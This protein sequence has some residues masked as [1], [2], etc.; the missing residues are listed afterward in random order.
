MSK[1]LKVLKEFDYD[2]IKSYRNGNPYTIAF[3][4]MQNESFCVKGGANDVHKFIL[5][6]TD[7]KPYIVHKTYFGDGE[8]R[9]FVSIEN[10]S[11]KNQAYINGPKWPSENCEREY[12]F[13]YGIHYN[14]NK[15]IKK[16][17]NV[18]RHELIVFSEDGNRF[19][20]KFRRVPRG[21]IKELDQFC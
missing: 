8:S 19:T 13:S 17:R 1:K 18:M 4:Y 2:P 14:D 6:Y 9:W 21:W 20:K 7:G 11:G 12:D 16:V 10:L 5:D 3:V 15:I